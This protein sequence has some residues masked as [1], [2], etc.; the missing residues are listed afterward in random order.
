MNKVSMDL[1]P[2]MLPHIIDLLDCEIEM[3]QGISTKLPDGTTRFEF[4]LPDNKFAVLKEF[5]QHL[6]ATPHKDI[7]VTVCGY[8]FIAN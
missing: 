1:T 4:E 7:S 2:F 6:M 3:L 8:K 5:L